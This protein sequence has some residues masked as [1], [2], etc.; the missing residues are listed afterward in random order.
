VRIAREIIREIGAEDWDENFPSN[1]ERHA[2]AEIQP[3]IEA[4]KYALHT[5]RERI[6]ILRGQDWVLEGSSSL[7]RAEGEQA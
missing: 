4:L 1:L 3:L 7:A 2:D 5:E 6:E